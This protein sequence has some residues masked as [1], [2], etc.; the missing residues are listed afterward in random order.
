MKKNMGAFDRF[1]RI[2][3]AIALVALVY[4]GAVTGIGVTILI[5]VAIIFLLTS[6]V[7]VCPLYKPFGINTC[8]K[9]SHSSAAGKID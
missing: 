3:I 5:A 4:T 9:T 7:G 1:I 2:A 8:K 6:F